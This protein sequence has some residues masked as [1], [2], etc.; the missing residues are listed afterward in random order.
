MI[1]PFVVEGQAAC[2]QNQPYVQ[3][4]NERMYKIIDSFRGLPG[5]VHEVSMFKRS[6]VLDLCKM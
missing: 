2:M 4:V 6:R 5:Y 1:F 3:K